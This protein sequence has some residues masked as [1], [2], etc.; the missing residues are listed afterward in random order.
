MTYYTEHSLPSNAQMYGYMVPFNPKPK[1]SF[2]V[3]T[4]NDTY[5]LFTRAGKI[6]DCINDGS[7]FLTNENKGVRA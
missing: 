2:N 6:V 3:F 7:V 4:D 1:D 5:Y